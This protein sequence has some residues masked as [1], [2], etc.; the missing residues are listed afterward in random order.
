MRILHSFSNAMLTGWEQAVQYLTRAKVAEK[1]V[2]T[3]VGMI[4]QVDPVKAKSVGMMLTWIVKLARKS[5]TEKQP[6]KQSS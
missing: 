4:S 6:S 5:N 1:K 3:G 2:K